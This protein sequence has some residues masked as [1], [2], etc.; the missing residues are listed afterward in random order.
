VGVE[1]VETE[2]SAVLQRFVMDALA[3]DSILK[4]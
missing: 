1:F 3:E 4:R 2:L